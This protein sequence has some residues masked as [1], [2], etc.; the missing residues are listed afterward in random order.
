VYTQKNKLNHK[1][2]WL[3]F[4]ADADYAETVIRV[5]IKE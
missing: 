2:S 4:R 5:K 1:N 3:N